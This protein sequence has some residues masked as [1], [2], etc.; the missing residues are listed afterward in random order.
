MEENFR[1]QVLLPLSPEDHA[2]V[3][4]FVAHQV[5]SEPVGG[6]VGQED[7]TLGEAVAGAIHLGFLYGR[8][9]WPVQLDVVYFHE[10]PFLPQASDGPD[11]IQGFPRDLEEE[12][13]WIPC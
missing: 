11:V 12:A 10:T 4:S 8:L 3:E 6:R 1:F 2:E 5:T 13:P 7:D 9:V